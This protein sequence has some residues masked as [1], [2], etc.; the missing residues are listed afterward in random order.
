M[1]ING[2]FFLFL[3]SWLEV[4]M[5]PKTLTYLRIFRAKKKPNSLKPIL[6]LLEEDKII[7]VVTSRPVEGQ[8]AHFGSGIMAPEWSRFRGQSCEMP[9][10]WRRYAS[11]RGHTH[12][13]A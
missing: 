9:Q 8:T 10:Y 5:K 2:L 12:H 11:I 6:L 7:N 4:K 1:L 13:Y 3:G